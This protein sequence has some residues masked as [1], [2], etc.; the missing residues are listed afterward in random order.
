MKPIGDIYL[1]IQNI[2][3]RGE[4]ASH[5]PSPRPLYI[6]PTSFPPP[7][8]GEECKELKCQPNT[9]FSQAA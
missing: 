5:R 9:S 7:F 1:P 2:N 3:P 8:E 4:D 6:Y